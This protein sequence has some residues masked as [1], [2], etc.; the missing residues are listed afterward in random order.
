MPQGGGR[1]PGLRLVCRSPSNGAIR[2][3]GPVADLAMMQGKSLCQRSPVRLLI[4]H[5]MEVSYPAG[6]RLSFGDVGQMKGL[7]QGCKFD[8]QVP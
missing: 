6:C 4:L 3:I 5:R 1:H 2:S 8:E 7:F